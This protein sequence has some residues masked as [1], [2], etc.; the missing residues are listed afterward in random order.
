MVRLPGLVKRPTLNIAV[1]NIQKQPTDISKGCAHKNGHRCV[2]K[3]RLREN[4]FV[5]KKRSS[6]S[7]KNGQYKTD[8][9][10]KKTA[11]DVRKKD[12]S[13]SPRPFFA[14]ADGRFF[15]RTNRF[16]RDRFYAYPLYMN[17]VIPKNLPI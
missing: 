17:M 16:Y 7:A 15:L 9:S 12:K 5:R 1:E 10:A 4:R 11:I 2:R 13:V 6:A 3:K 8:L 14:D